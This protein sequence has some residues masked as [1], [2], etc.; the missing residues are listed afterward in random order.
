MKKISRAR[1]ARPPHGNSLEGMIAK[2]KRLDE[3]T[4]ML[5]TQIRIIKVRGGRLSSYQNLFGPEKGSDRYRT[6]IAEYV[7]LRREVS[8]HAPGAMSS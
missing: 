8:R 5:L 6:D 4:Q 1:S 7:R 2:S 3:L